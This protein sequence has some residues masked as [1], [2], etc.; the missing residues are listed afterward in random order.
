MFTC[1]PASVVPVIEGEVVLTVPSFVPNVTVVVFVSLH[2]IPSVAPVI[3]PPVTVNVPFCTDTPARFLDVTEPPLISIVPPF[4]TAIA[5]VSAA[6]DVMV[7][8]VI[9]IVPA[10]CVAMA[11]FCSAVMLP[12]EINIKPL[13]P[14]LSFVSASAVPYCSIVVPH[15]S[16]VP[17]EPLYTALDVLVDNTFI[18]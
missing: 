2:Q 10:D 6:F 14:V 8:P 9:L 1:T 7:P 4:L 12:D 16:T 17:D 13:A 11:L 5:S 18:N 3:V 15:I